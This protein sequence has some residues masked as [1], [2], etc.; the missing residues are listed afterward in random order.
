MCRVITGCLSLERRRPLLPISIWQASYPSESGS[1][2]HGSRTHVGSCVRG[3]DACW[4]PV[5]GPGS[6]AVAPPRRL[7]VD[8]PGACGR[9]SW[10]EGMR[11]RGGSGGGGLRK[12]EGQAGGQGGRPGLSGSGLGTNQP[13]IRRGESEFKRSAGRRVGSCHHRACSGAERLE[14]DRLTYLKRRASRNGDIG[15]MGMHY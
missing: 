2:W 7:A 15:S 1:P 8:L 14:A 12:P 4:E 9:Q 11:R 5:A 3:G 13:C 10:V 6:C